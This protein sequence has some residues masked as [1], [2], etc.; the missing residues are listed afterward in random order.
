MEVVKLLAF[1]G[2]DKDKENAE[3]GQLQPEQT[4][5]SS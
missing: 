2:T 5:Y 4:I 1:I 3:R